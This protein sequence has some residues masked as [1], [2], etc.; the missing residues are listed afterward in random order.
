MA[1][2]LYNIREEDIL[3]NYFEN[4]I[5]ILDHALHSV[6]EVIFNRLLEE[7]EE[8]IKSQHKII[9]SGLG[10]N[11]PICE[12]FV[13][14]MSSLGLTSNFLHTNSAIHG[15]IGMVK[16]GDLVIVLTKSGS[17]IESV[18]LAERLQQREGVNLWLITFREESLLVNKIGKEKSLI[19]KLEHEGDPW[20]IMPNNSTTLNLIV[21]QSLVMKLAEKLNLQLDDFK[22]NHP[23]GAIGERLKCERKPLSH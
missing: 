1:E 17:T 18:Y 8:T 23:G 7:L 14:T 9:V 13:G 3:I 21:L 20:N 16:K 2:Y 19:I 10:K 6:E 12:K 15:D 5:E 4:T 11:V 22:I